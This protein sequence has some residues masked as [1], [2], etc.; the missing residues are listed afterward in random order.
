MSCNRNNLLALLTLRHDQTAQVY[1]FE[2]TLA[3]RLVTVINRYGFS[4]VRALNFSLALYCVDLLA[5]ST[6]Y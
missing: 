4:T 2:T 6:V 5:V 3:P 1:H